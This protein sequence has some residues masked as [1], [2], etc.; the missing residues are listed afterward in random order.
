M[1]QR[2]V[3][4]NLKPAGWLSGLVLALL[5]IPLLVLSFFFVA[6]A[7]AAAAVLIVVGLA[8]YYWLRHSMRSRGGS[9]T[10]NRSTDV[11]DVEPVDVSDASDAESTTPLTTLPPRLP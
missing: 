6:F 11:I 4:I 8:R 2:R 3:I 7:A 9:T 10:G 1:N 5:A